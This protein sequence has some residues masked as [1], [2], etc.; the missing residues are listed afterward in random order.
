MT[1]Q[2]SLLQS[3][4]NCKESCYSLPVATA[5]SMGSGISGPRRVSHLERDTLHSRLCSGNLVIVPQGPECHS[6]FCVSEPWRVFRLA[7]WTGFGLGRAGTWTW[8]STRT[9]VR[10]TE[11]LP[12]LQLESVPSSPCSLLFSHGYIGTENS[13]FEPGLPGHREEYWS[14]YRHKIYF[15]EK[16]DG[17]NFKLLSCMVSLYVYSCPSP[18]NVRGRLNMFLSLMLDAHHKYKKF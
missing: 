2:E 14:R 1:G 7:A 18:E 3:I 4:L 16:F 13:P 8:L 5:L 9:P 10:S 6:G 11:R 15:N 12:G 17:L